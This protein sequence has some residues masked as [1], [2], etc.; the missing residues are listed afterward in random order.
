LFYEDTLPEFTSLPSAGGFAE[1]FFSDAQQRRLCREPNK[2]HSAKPLHS[3]KAS[4]P[5]AKVKHS[6]KQSF[7]PYFGALNEFK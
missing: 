4:L 1:P 2:K 3:A 5:S 6:A 7:K